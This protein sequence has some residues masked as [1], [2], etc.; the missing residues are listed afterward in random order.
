MTEK[1]VPVCPHC[2]KKMKK[3]KIPTQSTWPYEFFYVCFNDEC[4]YFVHG[5]EHM[6]AQQQTRA[7]YRCRLDPD[8]GRCMPLP[9]WSQDAL[10]DD[11]I[12]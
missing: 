4:P 10:K 11:I 1:T 3:W 6:W 5:W 9:V 12:E 8:T 7:S 2:A